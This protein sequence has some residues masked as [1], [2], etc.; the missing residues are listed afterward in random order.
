[1]LWVLVG[2]IVVWL[3]VASAGFRRGLAILAGVAII[4]IVLLF[5]WLQIDQKVRAT[6]EQEAKLRIPRA[7]VELADLRMGTDSSFVKLTGRVRNKD[8][9]FTLTR[10]EL[11]LRVQ[12]CSPS[13]TSEE[14]KCDTVGDTTES[15][16]VNVP[17]QQAREIDDYVS[18]SGIGSPR[19]KRTWTY[20]V[21]SISG[22][23]PSP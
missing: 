18:F 12:E 2:I 14:V 19:M 5:V 7:N 4:G 1:V 21:V 3:A 23:T 13:G 8:S 11:R 10:L 15:I 20:D 9:R 17:P 22:D 6:Q 16:Y